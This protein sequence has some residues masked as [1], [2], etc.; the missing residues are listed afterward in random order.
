MTNASRDKEISWLM[1]LITAFIGLAGG[2][3]G[4]LVGASIQHSY[5][6]QL[7]RQRHLLDSR[8]NAYDN[9]F[10]GQAKLREADE[11]EANGFKDWADKLRD[12]YRMLVK[13]SRFQIGVFGTK[14]VIDNLV[15]YFRI[16]IH[17]GPCVGTHQKWV[18][19][20]K[21]YQ[22]MRQEVFEGDNSQK[23]DDDTLLL[24][25]FDCQLTE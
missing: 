15:S 14:Q 9:F 25:L 20:I 4:V 12:D 22:Y 23:V 19:D 1:P 16:Y 6:V 18:T 17:P 11:L 5:A 8:M 10:K 24:L 21:T 13:D 2:L 7:E 3:G